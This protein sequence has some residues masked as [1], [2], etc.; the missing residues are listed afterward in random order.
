MV[1]P[2]ALRAGAHEEPKSKPPLYFTAFRNAQRQGPGGVPSKR[3]PQTSRPSQHRRVRRRPRPPKRTAGGRVTTSVPNEA[4]PLPRKS[5][6]RTTPRPR[7]RR[8]LQRSCCSGGGVEPDAVRAPAHFRHF[9]RRARPA[10]GRGYPQRR[11]APRKPPPTAARGAQLRRH[12]ARGARA[13]TKSCPARARGTAGARRR[14][15]EGRIASARLYRRPAVCSAKGPQGGGPPPLQGRR[16]A[17][18]ADSAAGL[19][20]AAVLGGELRRLE[21]GIFGG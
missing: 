21:Q 13:R 12:K 3:P 11:A 17:A 9:T 19:V 2:K 15:A 5:S 7:L 20:E 10:P 4:C 18:A 16:A 8:R 1:A 6:R 14:G